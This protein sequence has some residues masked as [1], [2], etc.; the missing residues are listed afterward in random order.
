[1]GER[2]RH[3][4]MALAVCGAVLAAGALAY[5]VAS[6]L[7]GAGGYAAGVAL[8]VASY[9]ASTLAIAWAD[10]INP[11]MVFGVGMG[12]YV[13]KFS[14]FGFMMIAV[15]ATDWGGKTPLAVG[16]VAGVVAWTGTQIWWTIRQ[17]P[18]Q[19]LAQETATRSTSG[20]GPESL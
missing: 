14:L 4:G 9:T 3:L 2:I 20:A 17:N 8:V 16:I 1:M 15:G 18:R 6:G 11:R 10:S 7:V 5:A 12:M 19:D 13:T